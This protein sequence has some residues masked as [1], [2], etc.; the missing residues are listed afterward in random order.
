MTKLEPAVLTRLK[1]GPAAGKK[2]P[3]TYVVGDP[4]EPFDPNQPPKLP[5]SLLGLTGVVDK[6]RFTFDGTPSA[7]FPHGLL[8]VEKV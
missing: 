4:D 1:D 6:I 2:G 8:A 3:A 7:G 5:R